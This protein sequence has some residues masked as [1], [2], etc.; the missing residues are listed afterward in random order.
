MC[1]GLLPKLT[2]E[3]IALGRRLLDASVRDV[4]KMILKRHPATLYRE[5][6][7]SSPAS[8][9]ANALAGERKA[10]IMDCSNCL[11]TGSLVTIGSTLVLGRHK[12]RK[13]P[14]K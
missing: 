3:Q 4:A 8:K 6:S 12:I 11:F 1:F 13:S 10:V 9:Q 14:L 5:L 2:L 7:K